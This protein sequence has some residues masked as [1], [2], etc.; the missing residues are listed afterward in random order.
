MP[1]GRPRADWRDPSAYEWLDDCGRHAFAWEWLRRQPDYQVAE[2]GEGTIA[3]V[4][5]L[6]NCPAFEA[7]ARAARPIWTAA[8]DPFLLIST[9]R[10]CPSDECNFDIAR[11]REHCTMATS[12]DGEHWLFGTAACPL[13]L[14]VSSGSLCDGPV[15]LTVHIERLDTAAIVALSRLIALARAGRWRRSHFPAE[16]RAKRWSQ[17]LRVHDALLDGASQRDIADALFGIES[18]ANWRV[19]AAPWRRRSQRLVEATRR[20]A[21]SK[22]ADWISGAFP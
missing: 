2:E 17:V 18:I 13:R 4:F 15:A 6:R 3:P 10:T 12:A 20:A 5:G 16:R 9:A 8:V 19:N 11:V 14:D 22:P 1:A 21:M 7:D